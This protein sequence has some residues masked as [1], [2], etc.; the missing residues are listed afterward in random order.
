MPLR[1]DRTPR[2]LLDIKKEASKVGVNLKLVK[3]PI[4]QT[5][6]KLL[7]TKPVFPLIDSVVR[8]DVATVWYAQLNLAFAGKASAK[9]AMAKVDEAA[10]AARG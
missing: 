10:K 1:S 5:F 8:A 2:L 3:D 6:L 4:L 7:Q 9:S